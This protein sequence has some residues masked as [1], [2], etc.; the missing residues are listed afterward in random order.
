MSWSTL[1]A[2]GLCVD[3]C[4]GTDSVVQIVEAAERLDEL[5]FGPFGVLELLLLLLLLLRGGESCGHWGG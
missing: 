4:G 2:A 3:V 5:F 1:S